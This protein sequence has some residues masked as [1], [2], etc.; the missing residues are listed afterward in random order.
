MGLFS[1]KNRTGDHVTVGVLCTVLQESY[2]YARR[3]R[4][5]AKKAADV[6]GMLRK[7]LPEAEEFAR[8]RL[9]EAAPA[10]E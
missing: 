2:A 3:R 9:A 7:A 1:T 8:E 10:G 4:A 6:L 5:Q